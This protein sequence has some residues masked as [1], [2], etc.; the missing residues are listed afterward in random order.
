M[1]TFDISKLDIIVVDDNSTMR[2]I[3]KMILSKLGV[4]RLRLCGD[5]DEAYEAFCKDPSDIVITDWVMKKMSGIELVKLLRDPKKSPHPGVPIIMIT[6]NAEQDEVLKARKAG[7]DNYLAKP[8]TPEAVYNRI[9]Q[10]IQ[11][12]IDENGPDVP[13]LAEM[14]G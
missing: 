1:T 11:K 5:G 10:V 12:R 9:S 3:L 7:I 2:A 8:V 13:A 4:K 14:E 6:S